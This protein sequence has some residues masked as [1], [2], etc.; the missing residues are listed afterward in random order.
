MDDGV[1]SS[2]SFVWF[3][4]LLLLEMLFYSFD[5]AFQ[6][7]KEA[8]QMKHLYGKVKVKDE[9]IN[10]AVND[11]RA[12]FRDLSEGNQSVKDVMGRIQG[13]LNRVASGNSKN[14]MFLQYVNEWNIIPIE[15]AKLYW[16]AL[17]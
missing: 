3:I 2:S 4:I 6:Y 15:N 14:K 7:R 8:E 1:A 9:E 16:S 5:S 13:I 17:V 12:C 11:W 10:S